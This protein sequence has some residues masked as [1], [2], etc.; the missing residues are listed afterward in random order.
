MRVELACMHAYGYN[1]AQRVDSTPMRAAGMYLCLFLYC[2]K[3]I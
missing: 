2:N 1:A 3:V